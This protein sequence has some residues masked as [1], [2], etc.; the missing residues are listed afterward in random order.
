MTTAYW[1]DRALRAE[2]K[3]KALRHPT[4]QVNSLP[5]IKITGKDYRPSCGQCSALPW[6]ECSCSFTT[7]FDSLLELAE[8]A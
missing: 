8:Q 4:A 3:L 6:E 5:G 7:K 1:K 2:K